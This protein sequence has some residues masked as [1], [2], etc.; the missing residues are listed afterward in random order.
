MERN[1]D[2]RFEIEA[3]PEPE[4][5]CTHTVTMIELILCPPDEIWPVETVIDGEI[6]ECFTT[7]DPYGAV[8]AFRETQV[9]SF[10][11]R[12]ERQ[13]EREQSEMRG[14]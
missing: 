6:I 8:E 7:D 5:G 13:F 4:M 10:E 1:H 2:F 3:H 12:M 9:F 14:I 11:E